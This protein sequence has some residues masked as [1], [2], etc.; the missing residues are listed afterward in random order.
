LIV[1]IDWDA[2]ACVGETVALNEKTSFHYQYNALYWPLSAMNHGPKSILFALIFLAGSPSVWAGIIND[3]TFSPQSSFGTRWHQNLSSTGLTAGPSELSIEPRRPPLQRNSCFS[4]IPAER[5]AT[6]E[7]F[8]AQDDPV[9]GESFST[10]YLRPALFV[11][12]A[13]AITGGLIWT[14]QRTY[15]RLND[16]KQTQPTIRRV[17]PLITNLGDGRAS[18]AIFG[19]FLVYSYLSHDRTSLQAAKIGLESFL[20]SGITVQI[21]KHTFGRERP[22]VAT[23]SGGRWNG[24]FV[25]LNQSSGKQGGYAHFDAFPSGHT[26]TAFAAAA[27]LSEV[28]GDSP[29][30]SYTSYS[31]ASVVAVSRV[32]ERT[33]WLSDCFVGGMIGYLSTQLVIHLNRTGKPVS[34]VPVTDGR[35]EGIALKVGL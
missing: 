33:H 32:M 26:A 28:Y 2:S 11:G 19:G 10:M 21:L 5:T 7:P 3:P 25:L 24:M 1:N 12:G 14:D 27:T 31:V 15:Q 30:V 16:W 29:W 35:H 23:V 8:S 17:S 9:E 4:I 20:L 13:L 34:L 18:A 22:S 6:A